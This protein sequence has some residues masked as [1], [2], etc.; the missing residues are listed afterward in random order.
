MSDDDSF[1]P[2]SG[3]WKARSID[4]D[5]SQ[6]SPVDAEPAYLPPGSESLTRDGQGSES[7][8]ATLPSAT[9][10]PQSRSAPTGGTVEPAQAS[11]HAPGHLAP[12]DPLDLGQRLASI[13]RAGGLVEL[14]P[15]FGDAGGLWLTIGSTSPFEVLLLDWR[16]AESITQ[17]V[18]ARH[19][20][21]LHGFWGETLRSMSQG[22]ARISILK[23]Y[24]GEHESDRLVQSYPGR[25]D[26]AFHRI[27]TLRG[28]AEAHQE[29]VREIWAVTLAAL[30]LML[31]AF[32]VDQVL[33]PEEVKALFG[34]SD[35][36]K[37]PR[38]VVAE[39]LYR[40]IVEAG[41]TRDGGAVAG[42]LEEQLF[43]GAWR[44]PSRRVA[45]RPPEPDAAPL[46]RRR[47]LPALSVSAAVVGVL[48][49]AA[50]LWM[51]RLGPFSTSTRGMD[52]AANLSGEQ[53]EQDQ[54]K[55]QGASIPLS[56]AT[57]AASPTTAP[58]FASDSSERLA[59][60]RER[61]AAVR[62]ESERRT[63]AIA[64]AENARLESEAAAARARIA[65][66]AEKVR[67]FLSAGSFSEA[68]TLLAELSALASR[69]E[70]ADEAASLLALSD[71]LRQAELAA[72]LSEVRK[73]E[74]ALQ[75]EKL[76]KG[77]ED[78]IAAEKFPEAISNSKFMLNDAELPSELRTRVQEL[79]ERASRLLADLMNSAPVGKGTTR[80]A[81]PARNPGGAP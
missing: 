3:A 33:Q 54:S 40:R 8:A 36:A 56:S 34:K 63:K 77:I 30:D 76:V 20:N 71:E 29:I 51:L 21:L 73:A 9:G 65:E 59:R 50:T 55:P 68:R 41:L 69:L 78:L 1:L 61:E 2:G 81:R 16:Q 19:R 53:A 49:S 57:L 66:G 44:H 39:H 15:D 45:V 67:Q 52:R 72:G 22:A 5:R 32:L 31:D 12:R 7:P 24:G 74:R 28:I 75:Y 79:Q 14:P 47:L 25:I 64:Q 11:S 23:K 70:L 17:E 10:G 43:S 60:D 38:E 58:S 26:S 6:G 18:V 42:S 27:S 4:H 37:V 48:A 35:A 62:A 13:T 46:P 80:R